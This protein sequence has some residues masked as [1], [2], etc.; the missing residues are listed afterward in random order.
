MTE[1]WLRTGMYAGDADVDN[2]VAK[3]LKEL[4]DHAL[5][6]SHDRHLA[7]DRCR[8]MGL[9]I[10]DLEKD[11]ALQDVVL[12]L[13]HACML[14]FTNSAAIKLIENHKGTAF[15]KLA[16]QIAVQGQPPGAQKAGEPTVELV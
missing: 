11:Q 6:K 14:T 7:A 16:K 8:D 13:H 1:E 3:V 2:T 4:G 15:I 10:V 9:K 12:S 5:T